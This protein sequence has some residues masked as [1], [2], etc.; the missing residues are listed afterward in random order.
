MPHNDDDH[1]TLLSAND[2]ANLHLRHTLDHPPDHVLFP[3]LHG[4]EGDN[5]AQN[6]FFASSSFSASSGSGSAG[7]KYNNNYNSNGYAHN[8]NCRIVPKVPEYRGLV[9]VACE[10]D[11]ERAGDYTTLRILRR[12]PALTPQQQQQLEETEMGAMG[13]EG[14]AA[15]AGGAGAGGAMGMAAVVSDSSSSEGLSDE[16]SSYEDEDDLELDEDEQEMLLMIEADQAAVQAANAMHAAAGNPH[17]NANATAH[18]AAGQFTDKPPLHDDNSQ[19]Q[20]SIATTIKNEPGLELDVDDDDEED[21]VLASPVQIQIPMHMGMDPMQ[22]DAVHVVQSGGDEGVLQDGE[23][24]VNDEVGGITLVPVTGEEKKDEKHYQGAHMHPVAHRPAPSGVGAPAGVPPNSININTHTNANAG[25][26]GPTNIHALGTVQDPTL[27]S[28]LSPSSAAS[29]SSSSSNTSLSLVSPAPSAVPSSPGSVVDG[30][31]DVSAPLPATHTYNNNSGV[32][33]QLESPAQDPALD[34]EAAVLEQ[35]RLGRGETATPDNVHTHTSMN[36]NASTNGNGNGNANPTRRRPTDPSAPPLF[37]STFR[38]KE[39]LRRARGAKLRLQLRIPS[40]VDGVGSG[41]A[42]ASGSGSNLNGAAGA[43]GGMSGQGGGEAGELEEEG[44]EFVPPIY[45]TLSDIVVYSPYGATP[46]AM[47]LA[48]RFKAAIKAKRAERL[49]AAGLGMDLED[50][51]EEEEEE[52]SD[53]SDDDGDDVDSLPPTTPPKDGIE[54][55]SEGEAKV[56]EPQQPQPPTADEK[57]EGTEESKEAHEA[58]QVEDSDDDDSYDEEEARAEAARARAER[59]REREQR[60]IERAQLK[61]AQSHFLKYEVYVLD[62]DEEE[63]RRALPYLMMRVCGAGVPGGLG[64]G[65]GGSVEAKKKEKKEREREKAEKGMDMDVDVVGEMDMGGGGDAMDVDVNLDVQDRSE[66]EKEKKVEEEDDEEDINI[67][68]NTVDFALREREEMRDLTKASEIIT[69]KPTPLPTSPAA[70]SSSSSSSTPNIWSPMTSPGLGGGAG[71]SS[72][73][74][75]AAFGNAPAPKASPNSEVDHELGI[76]QSP[77]FDPRIGQVFLGNSGDVPLAPDVVNQFRNPMLAQL[78]NDSNEEEEEW[79]WESMT[80][81]LRGVEGLLEEFGIDEKEDAMMLS[82]KGRPLPEDDPFNY[83]STNNPASGFGY[84]ICVECHDLAPFPSTAHLRAAEEHMAMLDTMWKERWD[85]M[86]AVRRKRLGLPPLHVASP[87]LSSSSQHHY[88]PRPPPHANAVIHL[89]FP[90]SPPNT[91]ATMVALMPVIRFLEKWIQPLPVPIVQPPPPLSMTSTSTSL[92]PPV[93]VPR[94][95]TPP[96]LK[97]LMMISSVDP[98]KNMAGV[99][100]AAPAVP[101]ASTTPAAA[102]GSGGGS[103]SRRWSSVTALMPSF[104]IFPGSGGSNNNNNSNNREAEKAT[105]PPPNPPP[106]VPLPPHPSRLRSFTSPSSSYHNNP[107]PPTPIQA[108]TRPLKILM[109]S[110]DGY[111]ES[112]VPAL[113]LLMAIKG[114]MLPE[115]YLELQVEKRRSFFV[116][117]PDLGI[118]RRVEGRLREERERE[119]EKE[120]ERERERERIANGQYLSSLAAAAVAGGGSSINANGKRTAPAAPAPP[121]VGSFMGRPAAKSISFAQAPPMVHGHHG[122][123]TGSGANSSVK[124]VTSL[125]GQA[126]PPL[127]HVPFEFG[128]APAFGSAFPNSSGQASPSGVTMG[129][130]AFGSSSTTTNPQQQQVIKGRPRATTSPWLPSL[131]GGDHQSWFNDPRFDGSFP[132]R[133]LPFLY[134]GNLNH[135]SNVYMLHALGITHVVSVGECALVPPPH[136]SMQGGHTNNGG[137]GGGGAACHR[138]GPGAHFVP[139]KGPGGQ[140]SLWIEEREGRIKV[141][142]IKGVCDDGIDTL[143]P[144]LEP[145]CDWI[146]KARQE[147]GQVLVHCRVG[148]SR[149]ATVT[150]SF[151]LQISDFEGVIAYVMKHLSL[152]LVDAYLIVR[153]RRLSVL[154]QPNMRLLYNLCGWEIKLAKER[155][156]GD[157]RKLKKELARALTWPYLAKEVHALNEKY[158]H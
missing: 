16:S 67:I 43:G 158:L 146:D 132:S 29:S 71:S 122:N 30:Y 94:P 113:C 89:P 137:S 50:E 21:S 111:T 54:G 131:F 36:V 101:P 13:E 100:A 3:F 65:V 51:E 104:P 119:K 4:L 118:L 9:W 62:A 22:L 112:S 81:H 90:S 145:I 120:R 74:A 115:A 127:G 140:G 121:R 15:G 57:S 144:Q 52:S 123:G 49:Q 91:Q 80:A 6:T 26:G 130:Q 69:L 116:Y 32:P 125:V 60:K 5:H 142:D 87:L 35:A 19:N 135:A 45:A 10:E 88:P 28:P 38:P 1:I 92:S 58:E 68:P 48:R 105:S 41:S 11:L 86:M 157:E 46:A 139:G 37:T 47:A 76:G 151:L 129:Q 154:I 56:E 152:P 117:Q 59:R 64:L 138:P 63:M 24:G 126:P 147:G 97:N 83:V 136:H 14:G 153:S 42:S 124:T 93:E 84:D 96:E 17:A 44:W 66:K 18:D 77:P 103:S 133:V 85:K 61:E 149:S 12:K 114:L 27:I 128:S 148:V 155:A 25:V 102:S 53:E 106:A 72:S 39:L 108:R 134:L 70:T 55:E 7:A 156:N 23:H 79:D 75:A 110:S 73:L 98:K 20:I 8:D 31:G 99:V 34:Q 143:E 82:K 107:I 141:L 150:V 109:Y 33:Q 95:V 2:F 40:A 78:H